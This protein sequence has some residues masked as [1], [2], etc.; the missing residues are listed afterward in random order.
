[1]TSFY[2]QLSSND[3]KNSFPSN[4]SFDF[5]VELS[6]AISGNYRVA[7]VEIFSNEFDEQLHILCDVVEPYQVRNSF[8][9]VLRTVCK[10][11]ELVNL[12]FHRLSRAIV[13][14]IKISFKDKNFNVPT[15]SL[16][17]VTCTL[18]FVPY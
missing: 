5:T 4:E 10:S 17:E 6:E 16:G 1:M 7:L 3:S 14:R 8:F 11:G 15:I 13:Q 18:R 2:V 9:P 12:Q